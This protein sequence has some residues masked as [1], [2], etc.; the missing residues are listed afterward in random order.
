MAVDKLGS[1]LR[2]G[3][4]IADLDIGCAA[5]HCGL[6]LPEIYSGQLETVSIGVG[7]NSNYL[8]YQDFVPEPASR[9]DT[10]DLNP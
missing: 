7:F 1:Y 8:P 5:Y 2:K 6:T 3:H 4:L 9:L 10:L